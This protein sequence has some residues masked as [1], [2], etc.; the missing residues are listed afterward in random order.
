MFTKTT[1]SLA[2]A[3]SHPI[4]F[5]FE[6]ASPYSMLSALR[7]F[8]ATR[9]TLP[10]KLTNG[11]PAT[12]IPDIS[13]VQL[14]VRPVFLGAVFKMQGQGFLPNMRVPIKAAYLFHDVSRTLDQLGFKGFPRTPPKS[15]PRNTVLA[16]RMTWML[17]QGTEYIQALDRGEAPAAINAPLAEDV[18]RVVAEFVW[19]V[20]ET[21]FFIE[22]DIAEPAIMAG[23]W[24]GCVVGQLKELGIRVPGGQRAAELAVTETVKK[25]FQQNSTLA[26]QEGVFGAPSFTTADHDMYWGNDR[27]L[28]ALN[29]YNIIPH[30]K[31]PD[32]RSAAAAT[33]KHAAKI[34]QAKNKA[35]L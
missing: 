8:H 12:H 27:M 23:I 5:W 15:W 33:Y 11:S 14:V 2:S 25:G 19:R 18:T 13:S 34:A 22:D 16:G 30:T 6:Y 35:N 3:M 7:I 21:E 9:K 24:D 32:F 28:D 29:H 26:V 1:F 20:Y 10:T 17:A 4:H 31:T